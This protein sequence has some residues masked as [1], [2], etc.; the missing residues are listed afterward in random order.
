LVTELGIDL[1]TVC[2]ITGYMSVVTLEIYL[3]QN[4]KKALTGVID[5][6]KAMEGC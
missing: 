6:V 5:K 1:K 4:N 2:L 3:K